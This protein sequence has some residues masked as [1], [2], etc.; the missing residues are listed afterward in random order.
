MVTQH[1]IDRP[2]E[3]PKHPRHPVDRGV[4]RAEGLAAIVAGEHADV[5]VQARQQLD[6]PVHR[7]DTHVGVQVAEMQDREAVE[8][9]RQRGGRIVFRRAWTLPALR[10]PRP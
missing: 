9:A 6:Q 2:R 10:C 8:R 5:V 3:M 7:R 1:A 4:E